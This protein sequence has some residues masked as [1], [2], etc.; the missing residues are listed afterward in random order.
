MPQTTLSS[1]A[2]VVAATAVAPLITD[3][4]KHWVAIPSV[5]LEILLGIL[6]GPQVLGWAGEDDVM[7][8][9]ADFG[10]AMLMFLA[11]YELK[12]DEVRGKPMRLAVV[13]WLISLALGLGFGALVHGWAFSSLIIGLALT[14]TA[15]GTTL[16]MVRDAGLLPTPLGARV[17]AVGAAGEFGPIIAVALVVNDQN[18][19]RTVLFLLAFAVVAARLLWAAA[20]RRSG[21]ISRL[22]RTTLGTSVQFA[23]RLCMVVV[24][25]MLWLAGSLGLDLLLGAFVAGLVVRLFLDAGDPEEGAVVESKIEAI[26]FGLLIPFFFVVSGMRYDLDALLATPSAIALLPLFLVLFLV[27]RGLPVLGLHHRDLPVRPR[28]TL[29]LLASAALPLVVV[30]TTIGTEAGLLPT[31]TASAMVGAGMLSVLIFPLIALRL[32]RTEA[33]DPRAPELP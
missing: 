5:V 26:G 30:I 15:L 4:V 17:L 14:T 16:P 12:I 27:I 20:N 6:I 1:F 33:P 29:A 8:F 9:I 28:W 3:R 31:S 24:V 18:P 32:V 23:V 13:G 21:R 22:V 19:A 10:L 11:G 25:F 2:V 7:G